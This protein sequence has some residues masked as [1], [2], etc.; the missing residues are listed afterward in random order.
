MVDVMQG[1]VITQAAVA[2]RAACDMRH[3]VALA[4]KYR[5]S[6][7]SH[8]DD[9]NATGQQDPVRVQSTRR[10]ASPRTSLIRSNPQLGV[11]DFSIFHSAPLVRQAATIA[12]PPWARHSRHTIRPAVAATPAGTI[13]RRA[14][15]SAAK[16]AND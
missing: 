9:R 2:D 12:E 3:A 1:A 15:R 4:L 16:S 7:N 11:T 13:D 5:R 6:A 10:R 8:A 14:C